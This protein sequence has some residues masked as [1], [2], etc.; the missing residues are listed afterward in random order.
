MARMARIV[1]S[2]RL[3]PCGMWG[4]AQRTNGQDGRT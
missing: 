1:G 4:D 2:V 3:L